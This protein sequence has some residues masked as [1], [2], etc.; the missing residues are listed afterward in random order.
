M[1]YVKLLGSECVRGPISFK[2][3]ISQQNWWREIGEKAIV[4]KVVVN[5]EGELV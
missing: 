1:Y 5:T 4:L 3:A 2:D